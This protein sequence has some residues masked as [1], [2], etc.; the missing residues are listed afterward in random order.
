M[1]PPL[2]APQSALWPVKCT[3][4]VLTS[5]RTLAVSMLSERTLSQERW[6]FTT[7]TRLSLCLRLF[8]VTARLS[9]SLPFPSICS[10][11]VFFFLSI[12]CWLY[13]SSRFRLHLLVYLTVTPLFP[14]VYR[15]ELI[16]SLLTF[17]PTISII[18]VF[19]CLLLWV[20]FV[21]FFSVLFLTMPGHLNCMFVCLFILLQ[22]A[23]YTD[24]PQH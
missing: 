16:L 10:S 18:H 4:I 12:C 19:I 17:V 11:V 14:S 1:L 23:L 13:L 9:A 2:C 15:R 21:D 24:Q 20:W 6:P 22:H 8:R 7:R 5:V 3:G